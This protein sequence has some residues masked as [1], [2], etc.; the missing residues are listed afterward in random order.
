MERKE[1]VLNIAK[2]YICKYT[3]GVMADR[4]A[5]YEAETAEADDW[6]FTQINENHIT[7]EEFEEAVDKVAEEAKEQGTACCYANDLF[8]TKFFRK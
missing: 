2:R 6:V 8:S 1:L 4:L 3:C 5:D 7:K